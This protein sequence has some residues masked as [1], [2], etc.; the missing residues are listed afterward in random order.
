MKRNRVSGSMVSL[1][2]SVALVGGCA[3]AESTEQTPAETEPSATA[4]PTE[5]VQ[6][7]F[8]GNWELVS[9][10]SFPE[11]GEA[12]DNGYIGRILYDE[13]GNMSAVGMPRSLPARAAEESDAT[14]RAGFAYFSTYEVFPEDGRVVHS[15]IGSP[16]TPSWVGTELVRYYEFEGNDILKLSL[17]DEEGRTTGTLTWS[18]LQAAATDQ[19]Q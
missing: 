16:M 1:V 13:H 17:R 14:P 2:L 5:T 6:S 4:E 3:A 15:V 18:R 11:D 9:F 10:K 8:V 7:Q 19:I 12:V